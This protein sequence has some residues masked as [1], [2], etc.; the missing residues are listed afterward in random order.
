[1]KK[2]LLAK[3][4]SLATLKPFTFFEKHKD[5]SIKAFLK[6]YKSNKAKFTQIELKM[7]QATIVNSFSK[8]PDFDIEFFK[9]VNK[10]IFNDKYVEAAI[11]DFSFEFESKKVSYPFALY[12][13]AQLREIEKN[14]QYFFGAK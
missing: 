4:I 2:K 5:T 9:S 8:I 14:K 11:R 10:E 6:A 12:S 13:E 3:E 1:M 7:V